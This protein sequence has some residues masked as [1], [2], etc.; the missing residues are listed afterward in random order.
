LLLLTAGALAHLEQNPASPRRALSFAHVSLNVLGLAIASALAYG[1]WTSRHLAFVPDIGSLLA[2]RGVGDYTLSMSHFFDLTG[3]SFS[4]LRL[5]ATL[6]CI[7]FAA[8]PV[9]SLSLRRRALHLASTITLALTSATVLF[10]APLAFT[11]FGPMLSSRDFAA[12]I[13][14]LERTHAIS[15]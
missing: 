7:A 9:L 6:A 10:A 8:G 12:V 11:R 2:H 4:A 3:P 15:P 13:Q 5:P 1:L 14:Q